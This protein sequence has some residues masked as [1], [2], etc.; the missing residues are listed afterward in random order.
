MFVVLLL[1]MFSRIASRVAFTGVAATTTAF[2]ANNYFSV[3]ILCTYTDSFIDISC[4]LLSFFS[5]LYIYLFNF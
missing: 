3:C 4:V 5:L 2:A 1:V